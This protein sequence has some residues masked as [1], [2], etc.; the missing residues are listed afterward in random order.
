MNVLYQVN[1]QIYIN[2]IM[3]YV[4]FVMLMRNNKFTKSYTQSVTK[5]VTFILYLT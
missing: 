5:K 2:F 4:F 1:Y 3:M